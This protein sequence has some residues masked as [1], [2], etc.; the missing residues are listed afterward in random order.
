MRR[1]TSRLSAVIVLASLG[2]ILAGC[3]VFSG[4]VVEPQSKIMLWN[5]QDL[6]GWKPFNPGEKADAKEKSIWSVKNGAIHCEGKP[7]GY[8]RTTTAYSNYHL[9]LEWRWPVGKA[10]NSGVFFHLNGPDKLWP[11][12]IET[13]L[14]HNNA[15]G[16]VLLHG[17]GV[18]IDG[19]NKQ[20]LQEKYVILDKKK[21]SSE[22][23]VGR[24]NILDVYCGNG[25]IRNVVNGVLQNEGTDITDNSG[26]IGLQN[27]GPVEFRN[28]Y[29]EPLK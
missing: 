6:S 23:P 27:E 28:I 18:T 20:D 14:K 4:P 26:W 7:D 9:H 19:E 10:N 11:R 8:M 15:G 29:L 3:Q 12:C 1:I 25:T 5:G 24:W 21:P 13:E 2:C 16:I 22:K 17:T